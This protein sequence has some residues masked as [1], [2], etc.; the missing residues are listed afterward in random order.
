[1]KNLIKIG[2]I[3]LSKNIYYI[4][5]CILA[6]VI[7]CYFVA[8]CPIIQLAKYGKE[9]VAIVVSGAIVLFFSFFIGL[10]IGNE[11]EDGILRNKIMAGHTQVRVYLSHY[12]TLMIAMTG[13]LICWL[14]GAALG[15]AKIGAEL[16]VYLIVALF[17]NA[18]YIA[19]IQALVFRLKKQTAGIVLSVGFFYV[20][21]N[22][23]LMGNFIYMLTMDYPVVNKLVAIIYNLSALGQCFAR[24]PLADPGMGSAM[25]QIPVSVALIA[26]A[27]AI[28]TV[29]LKKRDIM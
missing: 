20:L 16:L 23:V 25:I 13:M 24:T 19:I 6:V 7:T 10:F 11:N 12:S 21:T 8:N 29:G 9:A 3:R 22:G 27:T 5:G 18:A 17:Y 1:M 4:L 15:G 14:L 2:L 28:G 26:L